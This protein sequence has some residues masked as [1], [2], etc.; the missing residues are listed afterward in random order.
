MNP[1]PCP[2]CG[3]LPKWDTWQATPDT[4]LWALVCS[5]PDHICHGSYYGT[6]KDAITDWNLSMERKTC[7]Q[8][9]GEK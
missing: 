9:G 6:K 3:R 4:I 8:K 7:K 2:E 5:G 1:N